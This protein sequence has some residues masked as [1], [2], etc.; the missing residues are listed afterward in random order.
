MHEKDSVD[1]DRCYRAESVDLLKKE[2]VCGGEGRGGRGHVGEVV[3]LCAVL[4]C[5]VSHQ[6]IIDVSPHFCH[7][8]VGVNASSQAR[9]GEARRASW[10]GSKSRGATEDKRACSRVSRTDTVPDRCF[11]QC[12]FQRSGVGQS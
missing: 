12:P 4:L 11:G 3:F 8:G 9:P 5:L 10:Y 6:R 1:G 7:S 2:K